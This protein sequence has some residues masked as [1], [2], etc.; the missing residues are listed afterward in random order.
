MTGN[1]RVGHAFHAGRTGFGFLGRAQ[2]VRCVYQVGGHWAGWNEIQ[3]LVN[4][5]TPARQ[6]RGFTLIELMIVISMILIL[7]PLPIPFYNQSI[8]RSKE[9][10]LQAEFVHV[11]LR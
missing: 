1:D 10:V 9:A 6:N 2:R 7:V 11:A 4:G 8:T 5:K 3:G